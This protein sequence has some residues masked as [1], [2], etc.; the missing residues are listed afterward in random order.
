M[1]QCRAFPGGTNATLLQQA[2]SILTDALGQQAP[3]PPVFTLDDST[4]RNMYCAAPWPGV[5]MGLCPNA[6]LSGPGVRAAFYASSIFNAALMAISPDDAQAAC[7]SAAILT[8]SVILPAITQ[9]KLHELTLHHAMLCLNFATLSTI[10]ALASA[11]VCGIWR[12]PDYPDPV[13][14]ANSSER[15]DQDT[16]AAEGESEGHTYELTRR[17]ADNTTVSD[18]DSHRPGTGSST[19]TLMHSSLPEQDV[20]EVVAEDEKK[21]DDSRGVTFHV[22]HREPSFVSASRGHVETGTGDDFRRIKWASAGYRSRVL[23]SMALIT[24]VSLQWAWA[25]FL[26]TSPEYAQTPCNADTK[27]LLFGVPMTVSSMNHKGKYA[28]FP[29]WLLAC[30]GI[31][32]YYGVA[33]VYNSVVDYPLVPQRRTS[34]AMGSQYTAV[35]LAAS[36]YDWIL[37][38]CEVKNWEKTRIL[39][40]NIVAAGLWVA[41]VIISEI[42]VRTN[43]VFDE[44]T[45]WGFGQVSALL[46]AAVPLWPIVSALHREREEETRRPTT[47]DPSVAATT[48]AQEQEPPS[49]PADTTP[50]P[51]SPVCT[52]AETI[53]ATPSTSQLELPEVPSATPVASAPPERPPRSP[54]RPSPKPLRI[55]LP[56]PTTAL[57]SASWPAT[58]TKNVEATASPPPRGRRTSNAESGVGLGIELVPISPITIVV[59]PPPADN[60]PVRRW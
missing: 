14:P 2:T 20:T 58:P 43:C 23:L 15:R 53:A 11:P 47:P 37:R 8:A 19:P 40:S 24:Q 10:A 7:W 18:A 31:T 34:T 30:M 32:L 5:C 22:L 4:L 26:F 1:V 33:L 51:G 27:I 28:A 12:A 6:D 39:V 25:A 57:D 9:K 60:P 45:E 49:T 29:L 44:S 41:L 16:T 52:V 54:S 35:R 38:A 46:L 56:P 50:C 17:G 42:Q 3:R 13:A 21:E 36:T 59:T 48:A 55:E